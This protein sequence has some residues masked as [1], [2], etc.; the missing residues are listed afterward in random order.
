[1]ELKAALVGLVLAGLAFGACAERAPPPASPAPQARLTGGDLLAAARLAG[2]HLLGRVSG[3]SFT[4]TYDPSTGKEWGHGGPRRRAGVAMAL[5][6]LHRA[7]GEERWLAAAER[8]LEGLVAELEVVPGEAGAIAI[9]DHGETATLGSS[10]LVLAALVLH[11]EVKGQTRFGAPSAALARFLVDQQEADGRFR[12]RFPPDPAAEAALVLDDVGEATFALARFARLVG[13]ETGFACR[14]DAERGAG[15]V[16]GV[17]DVGKTSDRLPRDALFVA[18]LETLYELSGGRTYYLHA[19]RIAQ[20]ILDAENPS[21]EEELAAELAAR[22]ALAMAARL[23]LARRLG[24]DEALFAAAA[25]RAVATLL[26]CQV[27]DEGSSPGRARGGF[28]LRAGAGEMRLEDQH[29]GLAALLAVRQ[30]LAG[31]SPG[32]AGP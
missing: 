26:R 13:G 16:L 12:P 15:W 18:A 30:V 27:Q 4:E 24:E 23:R 20:S 21:G 6:D 8:T 9:F 14:R 19:R 2:D 7:S 5:L 29:E 1:M 32:G 28:R 25:Q 10:A 31:A 3:V 11:A 17:R 22:Q